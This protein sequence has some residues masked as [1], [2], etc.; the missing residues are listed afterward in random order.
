MHEAGKAEPLNMAGQANGASSSKVAARGSNASTGQGCCIHEQSL[1]KLQPDLEAMRQLITCKICQQLLSEPYTLTCG[2][3]FCY[4][5]LDAWL[6]T[7]Q[8]ST[9]PDCRT[10]VKQQPVPSFVIREMVMIFGSKAELLPDGETPEDHKVHFD[11]AAEEVARDKAAPNGGGLFKGLF[12]RHPHGRI[13]DPVYDEEDRV[14]RC[15]LCHHEVEDGMCTGCGELMDGPFP[16][17]DPDGELDGEVDAYDDEFHADPFGPL[18]E[19][20]GEAE[21]EAI[22]RVNRLY[23]M[24]ASIRG[25]R[26]GADRAV[27]NV[28]PSDTQPFEPSSDEDSSSD[29]DSDPTMGGFVVDDGDE[30]ESDG[31]GDD[32][33]SETDVETR[34]NTTL[35]GTRPR[36]V[37]SRRPIVLD[38]DEG[39]DDAPGASLAPPVVK[40]TGSAGRRLSR[41]IT[42][43]D[44]ESEEASSASDRSESDAGAH[45]FERADTSPIRFDSQSE[46]G[47]DLGPGDEGLSE[48]D[49]NPEDTYPHGDDVDIYDQDAAADGSPAPTASYPRDALTRAAGAAELPG[50]RRR[51][52]ARRQP[53]GTSGPSRASPGLHRPERTQQAQHPFQLDSTLHDINR[54]ARRGRA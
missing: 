16:F 45:H 50:S 44:D 3:T 38:S 18:P 53:P 15:P 24:P 23:P 32:D 14:H 2:H 35:W 47:Y 21:L 42:V 19:S 37:S 33:D 22:R 49:Y 29:V 39:S 51:S 20:E 36:H 46:D 27:I 8:K 28:D 6:V 48:A 52:A 34:P 40:R 17:E 11:E 30:D 25:A 4:I 1:K 41:P 5:C 31:S 13:L 43:H 10:Y 9:C 7:Q 12:S 26:R 54:R